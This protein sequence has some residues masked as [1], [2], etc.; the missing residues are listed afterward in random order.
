M[1]AMQA[2]V[3]VEICRIFFVLVDGSECLVV[4]FTCFTPGEIALGTH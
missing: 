4:G 3:E 2:C 1:L